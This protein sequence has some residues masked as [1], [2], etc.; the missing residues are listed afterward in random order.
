[1][2]LLEVAYA[3]PLSSFT[4]EQQDVLGAV[5]NPRVCYAWIHPQILCFILCIH[6]CP[7]S[8]TLY[9]L[10]TVMDITTSRM[11]LSLTSRLIL[12]S[13]VIL[14]CG[15]FAASLKG[16]PVFISDHFTTVLAF[17]GATRQE[18]ELI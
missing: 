13:L 9:K 17:P 10:Y 4:P 14:E 11:R 3:T 2:S 16:K 5:T 18:D 6:K 8:G 1:M 15:S 12:W 7:V